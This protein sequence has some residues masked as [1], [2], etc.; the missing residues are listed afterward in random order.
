MES[1]QEI[2]KKIKDKIN[3]MSIIEKC[4]ETTLL[5]AIFNSEPKYKK[6][7]SII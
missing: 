3:N 5:S 4:A 7:K 6:M 1:K 2:R